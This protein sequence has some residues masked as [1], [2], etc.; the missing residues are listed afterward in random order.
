MI[1]IKCTIFYLLFFC[2]AIIRAQ[3]G[4]QWSN[5]IEVSTSAADKIPVVDLLQGNIPVV[6][7]GN[8]STIY[9]SKMI[10]GEFTSPLE[11]STGGVSPDIY[12]FGG[13]D[14]ATSGNQI[15]IVFENFTNGI[16]LIRSLDGGETFEEPVNVID[17]VQGKWATLPSIDI[18]DN[19][20]LLVSVI[21]ENANETEANYIVMRSL[22]GGQSFGLPVEASTTADGDYVCECCPS[23]LY[24]KGDNVWLVFRNNDNNI[25][26]IWMSKS[27]DGGDSFDQAV[28]VDETDWETFICPTSTPR[29]APLANDKLIT[30]WR[31][32]GSG[33]NRVYIS[34]LN[35]VTMEYDFQT[36]MPLSNNEATQNNPNIAGARDT[37][38]LVWEETGFGSNFTDLM[39]AFSI[40][41][42]TDLISNRLNITEALGFQRYPSLSYLDGFFHLVYT[43]S[44]GG[45]RYLVGEVTDEVSRIDHFP[46]TTLCLK[47]VEQPS[48][49]NLIRLK[50]DCTIN[51]FSFD[52]E[53]FDLA[54][55]R[56]Q[57]WTN[58]MAQQKE[59]IVL[60]LNEFPKGM[61]LLSLLTETGKWTSKIVIN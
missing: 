1:K 23:D 12:S 58:K 13:I 28:D 34:T 21:L 44:T 29:I 15:Y 43:E 17:P 32:A 40:N 55:N 41:G 19:N 18:D 38:G 46:S 50:N 47:I 45:I 33:I 48:T 5:P 36:E 6:I 16:F 42:T 59:E 10:D 22:D 25:R 53:L 2:F 26:D 39:F 11:L 9:F 3:E 54:G 60:E 31:S 37:I 8:N 52:A 24:T 57:F 49:N 4:I 61:Y 56:V 7:W 20:N 35:G 30:T 27:S 51:R 14:M